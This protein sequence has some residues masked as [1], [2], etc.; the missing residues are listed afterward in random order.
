MI[1]IYGLSSDENVNHIRYVG[2]TNNLKS[3]LKKHLQKNSLS[4]KTYKN[5]WLKSELK[6]GRKIIITSLETIPKSKKWEPFEIKWIKLL[7]KQGHKLTNS[8]CGGEGIRLIKKVVK[9]RADTVRANFRKRVSKE[10][11]THN[12]CK[13]NDIWIGK[14]KCNC[15]SKEIL[16][17]S[18]QLYNLIA[19]LKKSIKRSCLSCR[20]KNRK[21]SKK[22]KMKISKFR[23]NLPQSTRDKL[24]K[25]GKNRMS[26]IE[27]KIK[28]SNS[29]K[30]YYK[31]K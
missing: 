8:T 30:K 27:T 19:L 22:A 7:K 14:R 1:T 5:N 16:H 12:I 31:Q 28:I 18:K 21:L 2:K 23:K 13:E 17:S 10:F 3:R 15:C 24:S 26:S 29:L 6:K 9:K 4:V 11:V 20:S 25:A